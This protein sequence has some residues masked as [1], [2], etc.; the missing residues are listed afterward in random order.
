M[1]NTIATLRKQRATFEKVDLAAKTDDRVN[2]D[3]TGKLNGEVF[4][5][6]EARD[7]P[8]VLGMGRMLP[9]FEAAV[10]GMRIGETK[11]FE[12]TFPEDYNSKDVAGKKVVFTITLNH[13]EE[14]KLPEINADFARSI[15]V[16]DAR[17]ARRCRDG[18][19]RGV[20]GV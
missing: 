10:V 5:G 13:V 2:I 4:A 19:V 16:P 3:F 18:G 8:V 17:H 7:Y 1:D 12:L 20:P 14:P 15:G 11:S 6:G 9:E